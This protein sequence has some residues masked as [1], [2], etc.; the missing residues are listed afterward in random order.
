MNAGLEFLISGNGME[1]R[2]II[3]SYKTK[4]DIE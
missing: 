1:I 3:Q 4:G 2:R